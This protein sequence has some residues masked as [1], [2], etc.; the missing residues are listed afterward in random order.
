MLTTVV[1]ASGTVVSVLSLFKSGDYDFLNYD[2]SYHNKNLNVMMCGEIVACVAAD[3]QSSSVVTTV[4]TDLNWPNA[5]MPSFGLSQY[6]NQGHIDGTVWLTVNNNS[7]VDLVLCVN[8][9]QWK[10]PPSTISN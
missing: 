1:P 10:T 7:S 6:N 4:K 9:R 3:P 5:N 8:G 2:F